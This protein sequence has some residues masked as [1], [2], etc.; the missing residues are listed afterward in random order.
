MIAIELKLGKCFFDP[1][2]SYLI[3]SLADKLPDV[4]S[5][6]I[7]GGEVEKEEIQII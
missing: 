7:K 4:K 5:F 3:V 6:R 2:I 1:N